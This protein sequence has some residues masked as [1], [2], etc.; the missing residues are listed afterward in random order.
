MANSICLHL[1]KKECGD[2]DQVESSLALK[3]IQSGLWNY[4]GPIICPSEKE[5]EKI[6]NDPAMVKKYFRI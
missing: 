1:A 6:A 5:A 4:K 2:L 3:D